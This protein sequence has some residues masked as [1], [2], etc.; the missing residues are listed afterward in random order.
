M[1]KELNY[2][3]EKIKPLEKKLKDMNSNFERKMNRKYPPSK[4]MQE[5]MIKA[6]DKCK[7]EIEILK[8][9]KRFINN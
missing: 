5:R 9:L 3:N 7:N 6:M 8:N 2:L 4:P 1:E